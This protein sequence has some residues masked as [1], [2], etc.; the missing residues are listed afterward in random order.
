MA[1]N[2]FINMCIQNGMY[3]LPDAGILASKL[4]TLRLAK[5]GCFEL[6]H[7]PGFWKHVS[8][9]ISFTLVVE[10]FDIKYVGKEHADHIR[11]AL[12]DHYKIEDDWE[13]KLYCGIKLRWNYKGSGSTHQ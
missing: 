8:R 5:K 9:P 11:A 2:G 3:E 7:T 6:L 4:L 1:K 10:K 13:G 12:T